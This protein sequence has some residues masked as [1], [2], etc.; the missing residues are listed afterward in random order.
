M[1]MQEEKKFDQATE[2]ESMSAEARKERKAEDNP[3]LVVFKKP[4][5]FEGKN[6]KDVNLSGLEDLSAADMI[7]VNKTIERGG[8][9]N[10]LPEMSLEYACLISAR[11]TGKPVEFFKA[12]PPKEALKIKNRVTNFLYGED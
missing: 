4:I 9:V 2:T 6:Y 10:V 8:T 12:L 1:L 11:A 3:Y 7:A 5:T